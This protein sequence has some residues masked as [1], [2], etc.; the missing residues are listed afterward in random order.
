LLYLPAQVH[1]DARD[2]EARALFEKGVEASDEGHWAEASDAFRR[3]LELVERQSTRFNLLTALYRQGEYRAAIQVG[4]EYLRVTDANEDKARRAEVMRVL[5]EMRDTMGTLE[6]VVEPRTAQV[7]VD[8]D[9]VSGEGSRRVLDLPPGRHEVIVQAE[10]YSPRIETVSVTRRVRSLQSMRLAAVGGA[11]P[12]AST[13]SAT[14]AAPAGARKEFELTLKLA[15]TE[16]QLARTQEAMGLAGRT[17]PLVLVGLGLAFAIS[18]AGCLASNNEAAQATGI[19]LAIGSIPFLIAGAVSGFV[20]R[21]KRSRYQNKIDAYEEY[22]R[23]LKKQLEVSA[24]ITPTT[25]SFNL[26]LR[27]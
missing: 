9:P 7:R 8:G 3:S 12:A 14:P 19:V 16:R 25:Q 27:F 21:S 23:S 6:I 11:A 26:Q 24:T 18:G 5:A 22:I 2:D 13:P 10:G 20:R 1:A 4:D 15:E 17:K